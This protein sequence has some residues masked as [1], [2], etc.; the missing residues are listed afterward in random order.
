M[1]WKQYGG[2][3][4][5]EKTSDL[6]VNNLVSD[7]LV[8]KYD[9]SSYEGTINYVYAKDLLNAQ[10]I[11]VLQEEVYLDASRSEFLFGHVDPETNYGNIGINTKTP[12]AS[13]D[14]QGP[15]PL[16]LNVFTD[17]SY[18]QNIIARNNNNRSISVYVDNSFSQL[19][20]PDDAYIREINGVIHINNLSTDGN[21]E[22]ATITASSI[23]TP[24]ITADDISAN[25]AEIGTLSIGTMKSLNDV[26]VNILDNV[27]EI[28]IG[29][30]TDVS[31]IQLGDVNTKVSIPNAVDASAGYFEYLFVE[32]L[33][34]G[35]EEIDVSNIVFEKAYCND[36]L[37]INAGARF[38]AEGDASMNDVYVHGTATFDSSSNFVNIDASNINVG[39]LTTSKSAVFNNGVT[40][41]GGDLTINN[42][43]S[44]IQW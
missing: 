40:V 3:N 33:E 5:Y 44:I 38:E 27:N 17:A 31:Y 21:F 18:N 16:T 34:F 11:S 10:K 42:N 37:Y 4:N 30:N 24:L 19:T 9:I 39:S 41:N 6:T 23:N 14:I 12:Q 35:Y 26:S 43:G 7:H 2:I 22:A 28:Y 8:S 20:F 32:N 1:S 13:L 36:L 25:T 29:V 15:N